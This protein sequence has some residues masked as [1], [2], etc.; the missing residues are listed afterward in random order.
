MKNRIFLFVLVLGVTVLFS[1]CLYIPKTYKT[2]LDA[3]TPASQ[4]ATIKF[5]GNFKIRTW[6]ETK[7]Y[8]SRTIILPAGNTSFLFDLHFTFSGQN[9]STTYKCDNIELRYLFEPGRKYKIKAKYKA[10]ALGFK[11][12]EFYVELYDTTKRSVKLKEWMVGKS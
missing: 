7:V 4:T 6:N 3:T 5:D 2:F 1:S 11:G 10:L 8:A 12:Y 9:S